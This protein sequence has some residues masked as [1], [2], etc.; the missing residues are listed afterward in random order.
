MPQSREVHKDYMRKRRGSQKG[1]QSTGFTSQGSQENNS[2]N[3]TQYPAILYALTD[4]KKRAKLRLICESLKSHHV[5]KEVRYGISGPTFD[6]VS[7][8][9]EAF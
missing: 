7:E 9:L 4:L 3:V 2:P 8:L 5:L 6:V 1:S